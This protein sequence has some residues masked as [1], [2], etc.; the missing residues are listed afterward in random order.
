MGQRVGLIRAMSNRP[1]TAPA[2]G[3]KKGL[4]RVQEIEQETSE[5][6]WTRIQ[7]DPRPFDPKLGDQAVKLLDKAIKTFR[8]R[9]AAVMQ[10]L[11]DDIDTIKWSN[12]EIDWIN[13]KVKALTDHKTQCQTRLKEVEEA[14]R[15]FGEVPDEECKGGKAE[16][17]DTRARSVMPLLGV[18][19]A[20]CKHSSLNEIRCNLS[21]AE[22]N[23]E[24]VKG[25]NM[26]TKYRPEKTA[27]EKK[28][29]SSAPGTTRFELA[30]AVSRLPPVPRKGR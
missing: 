12:H 17:E 20:A 30:K 14:L 18:S 5:E 13:K 15:K 1:T 19:Q 21:L 10:Q 16:Y 26:K 22:S 2:G 8:D 25:F 24:M 4:T 11:D 29:A 28:R 6:T 7:L 3:G 9:R 23:L 27:E